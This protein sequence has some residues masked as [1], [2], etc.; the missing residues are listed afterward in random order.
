MRS[1]CEWQTE[2]EWVEK[3]IALKDEKESR[4]GRR[5][6][7]LALL[8][9]PGTDSYRLP[10]SAVHGPRRRGLHPDLRLHRKCLYG[11]PRVLHRLRPG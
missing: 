5:F 7:R 9:S 2:T 6:A 11:R 8:D 3:N 10:V 1:F 4:A